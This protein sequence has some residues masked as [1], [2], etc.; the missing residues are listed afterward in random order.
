MSWI[1]LATMITASAGSLQL[2][3]TDGV[4]IAAE[5]WGTGKHGVLLL[6]EQGADHTGWTELAERLAKNDFVVVA[7]D[8]RGH[9]KS[10]GSLDDAAWLKMVADAQAG[11]TWL[12][13]K[14]VTDVGIVGAEFGANLALATLAA[15]KTVDT[16]VLLSPSL[17]ANGLKVSAGLE[18]LARRPLLLVAT[19]EDI[20]G[21]RAA[22]LIA[23]KADGAKHYALYAGNAKGRKMLNTAPELEGLM[24]SWLNGT[25]LQSND[26]RAANN[27]AVE[28]S[29]DEVESTG[30]RFEDK[31]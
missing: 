5:S 3:T 16:A 2:K 11:I 10:G 24:V 8:L 30:E 6:H 1:A 21:A 23:D 7:I 4:S 28:T 13:S 20:A 19:Q 17:S 15:N 29:V 26:P 9:G 18:G 31:H 27:A 25:F 22:Q 12:D 14:G